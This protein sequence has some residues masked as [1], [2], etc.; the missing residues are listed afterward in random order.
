MTDME[1][2][3]ATSS[4]LEQLRRKAAPRCLLVASFI[5][6]GL[7]L[8][9]VQRLLLFWFYYDRRLYMNHVADGHFT[10]VYGAGAVAFVLGL[11]AAGMVRGTPWRRPALGLGAWVLLVCAAYAVMHKTGLLL[12]YGEKYQM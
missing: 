8:D 11:A 3:P 2:S 9:L 6:L 4:S 12:K 10:I 7:T 5:S 1:I